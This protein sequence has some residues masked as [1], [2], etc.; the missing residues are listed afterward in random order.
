MAILC[1]GEILFDFISKSPNKGL[2]ES[3]LFEKRPGGSPFNVAVGLAKLGADVSFLT[4]IAQDQ[5]GKFLFE[6]LK[7]NGVNTDYSF[8]AEG[9]KTCLAFAAVDAQGKAEYEFYRDDAADTRLELKDIANL[10]YEKFNIFHFGSIALIDE[11]TSSTLTR[12]F[13]NFISRGLLTSFDPNVRKSLLKN[14]ESYNNLVKSI[15]KKVDILK[16]SDDDLFYISGK[17]DVEEAI[18]TLSIKEG[19]ILFVTLG[20]EGSL[21]YKDGIIERVPGYKVKVVETVGCGDSFMAGILYKLR[22][23]SKEDFYSISVEE[24]VDYAN[25]ANKCAAVV[26]TKQG[27]ANAMPTLSEVRQFE[28]L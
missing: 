23:L 5:F 7:E 1:A 13:D 20:S 8:R 14:R 16:M 3:G 11:P 15:I 9:L 21:V 25:F 18:R 12:L 26:A 2:G 10:Q 22:D 4:K 28:F 24:L 19:S 17:K 6:Y 27:A